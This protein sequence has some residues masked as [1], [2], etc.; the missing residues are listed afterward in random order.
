MNPD[1]NAN[2]CHS[3]SCGCAHHWIGAVAIILIGVSFLLTAFGV[4]SES[5]N[6]IVWPI[7]LIIAAAGKL[8]RCCCK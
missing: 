2:T 3:C 4:Y 1:N 7:L 5:V 8:C 6:S